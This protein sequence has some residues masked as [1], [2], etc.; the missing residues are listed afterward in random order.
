MSGSNGK[1]GSG[2]GLKSRISKSRVASKKAEE[3]KVEAR[4]ANSA[5]K[6]GPKSIII[7]PPKF[8]SLIITVKGT[9]RLVTHAFGEKPRTALEL[10]DQ[11]KKVA[12][13]KRNPDA[14]GQK[15]MKA[16]FW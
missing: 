13:T 12:K 6:D 16:Y 15:R 5:V 1:N 10:R 2:A 9:S 11:Q 4:A 3:K 14:D 8:T 7:T